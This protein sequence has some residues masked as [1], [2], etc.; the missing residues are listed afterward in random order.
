MLMTCFCLCLRR[1][2]FC[3]TEAEG[4]FLLKPGRGIGIVSKCH[5]SPLG[6]ISDKSW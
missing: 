2:E 4:L 6:A 5:R 1:P 3:T